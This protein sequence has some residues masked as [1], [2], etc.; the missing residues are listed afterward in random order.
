MERRYQP[1]VLLFGTTR[2]RSVSA[3]IA[4]FCKIDRSCCTPAT[5]HKGF[6]LATQPNAVKKQGHSSCTENLVLRE[7]ET[8][9]LD[10]SNY[11]ESTR[12]KLHENFST[13]YTI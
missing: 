6:N 1:L 10:G 13:N 4:T 12:A 8:Q 7:S 2:A 3:D 5:A 11:P 9:V